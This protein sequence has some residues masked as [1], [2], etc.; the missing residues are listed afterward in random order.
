MDHACELHVHLEG[1][2]WPSHVRRWWARANLRFPEPTN[3]SVTSFESFLARLRY[4]YNFLNEPAAYADVASAY[5]EQAVAQGI[6]Y[7]ELQINLAL[8]DAWDLALSEVLARIVGRVA[9]VPRAPDLRFVIDLPW[10]F[11]AR[12]LHAV[13]DR[14]AELGRLGVRGISFGGRESEARPAEAAPVAA[15]ARAA[16]LKVLCH[17]GEGTDSDLAQ[18][19][20]EAVQPD[21]VTHGVALADWLAAQGAQAPPVDVCLSSNLR[22]GVIPGLD[23]HPLRRWWDA[24]VPVCLATDDPAIFDTTLGREYALATRLCPALATDRDRI[25]AH[26]LRAALDTTAAARALGR[27]GS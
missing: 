7:A 25:V 10:Q 14:I 16:G 5:A 8:L 2:V 1:C 23:A 19:I 27:D 9:R 20:V 21:R 17:A 4:G 24:G 11:D 12:R 15:A 13:V 18:R 6:R 22:L 3:S 26:W